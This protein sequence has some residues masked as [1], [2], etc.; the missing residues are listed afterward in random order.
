VPES[1]IPDAAEDD[2]PTGSEIGTPPAH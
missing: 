1:R 2:C